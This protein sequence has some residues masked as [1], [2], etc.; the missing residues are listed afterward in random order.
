M[1]KHLT[2]EEIASY[3]QT[4]ANRFD[5]LTERARRGDFEAFRERQKILSRD[6]VDIGIEWES[7]QRES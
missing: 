4:Q 3:N 1:Y 6:P 2:K 5:R 7:F